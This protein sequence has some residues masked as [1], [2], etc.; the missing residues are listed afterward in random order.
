[1]VGVRGKYKGCE[2]CR[3]RRVKCDNERPHCRKCIDSGRECAGYER[4]MVFITATIDDAGRCSSHPPRQVQPSSSRSSRRSQTVEDEIPRLVP[5]EPLM[6]AWDD[7]VSVSDNGVV[8]SIQIAALH[9]RFQNILRG[10][11]G[12][13]QV[14]FRMVLP[15]Y[16]PVDMETWD[17]GG[18]M[19]LNA[20]NMV[21][22]LPSGNDNG[23]PEGLCVFLF[24]QNPSFLVT[25]GMTPWSVPQEHMDVVKKLGPEQFRQFP[26]HHYFVRVYRCNA[27]ILALLH[28]KTTFLS[29]F[30]WCT[31]PWEQHPKTFLDRLFDI[32]AG[33]PGIFSRVD[34][35]V[36]FAATLQRRLKAQELLESC[37]E[38]ER[39]LEEWESY[40][41]AP[42]AE[43]PY[44]YWIEEPDDP[45]A[46]QLPFADNFAFK[47]GVSSVMFLYHW[48]TLL[49]LHRCI[50]CLHHT[51]FQ[52]VIE[53]FPNMY[54]DLPPNLQ[55]NLGR[56]QQRREFASRICRALDFALSTTVQ[57]DMLVAPLAVA[58][59]F[60]REINAS[61]RDGEL[62]IMWCDNFRLRLTSKGHDI[63]N[64]LQSRSWADIARF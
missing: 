24:E 6:P 21:S 47:D 20:Q 9:T 31:T 17:N 45:D 8:Y 1:M 41:R 18:N 59:E 48:M 2:T 7:L 16:S 22:L 19:D 50:E 55:I 23:A 26:A 33:L 40:A 60:Y 37:L 56:Y 42:T 30:E 10:P 52:P 62:E 32:I 51:I 13:S 28:R 61:S 5:T 27:I 15:S 12:Q 38:I 14:K 64:V 53:D 36:P 43:H 54:P 3:A 29:S 4:E 34:R 46:Q 11:E 58:M 25:N 57:P 39:R 44:A 49:L 63:A 35:T